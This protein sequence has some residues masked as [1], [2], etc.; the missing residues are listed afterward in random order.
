MCHRRTFKSRD[1][2]LSSD[3]DGFTPKGKMRLKVGER[4]VP[5]TEVLIHV[6]AP[7][8]RDNARRKRQLPI[9]RI[10]DSNGNEL[11]HVNGVKIE[12]PSDLVT[13]TKPLPGFPTAIAVL[14]T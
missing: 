12:G 11:C 10:A 8:M 4:L 7:R 2:F 13:T 9:V 1:D 6:N 5:D 3:V 14:R